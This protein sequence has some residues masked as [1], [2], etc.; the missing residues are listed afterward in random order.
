MDYDKVCKDIIDLDPKIRFAGICDDTGEILYGGMREGITSHLSPDET[1]K[2]VQLA[3][4][5]WGLRDALSPKTGRPK[6]AMA[7]YEKIKR[8]T[9]PLNEDYLLLISMEVEADHNSIITQILKII[10]H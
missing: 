3:L 9:L 6:Y 4:G 1:R 2:S 7:E 10:G 5:R 8:A